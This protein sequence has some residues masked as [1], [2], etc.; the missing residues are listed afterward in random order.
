VGRVRRDTEPNWRLLAMA[1]RRELV[2]LGVTPPPPPE[3]GCFD[4]RDPAW[5]HDAV[6]IT[7]MIQERN[8]PK[9]WD[10]CW[11]FE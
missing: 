4:D 11:T 6:E 2:A 3:P 5:E 10:Q 9:W 1:R 7:V 8:L